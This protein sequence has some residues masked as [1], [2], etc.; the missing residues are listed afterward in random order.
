M[1]K[2]IALL[3]IAAVF[4]VVACGPSAEDKKKAE[5]A[6]IADS[7][8]V[9]DSIAAA[10]KAAAEAAMQTVDTTVVDSTAAPATETK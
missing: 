7:I 2:V 8:R 10:E 3:S 1:K 5:E 9:A 6:R 4:A